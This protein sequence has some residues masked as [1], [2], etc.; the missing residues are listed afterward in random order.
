[1]RVSADGS[2]LGLLVSRAIGVFPNYAGTAHRI[3]DARDGSLLYQYKGP[4]GPAGA[5]LAA[6]LTGDGVDEPFFFGA[7]GRIHVQHGASGE[8]IVHDLPAHFGATPIIADP[9]R[10]GSLEL[11]GVA[12]EN[13]AEGT[14]T[15]V[16]R[17]R[18]LS[19]RLLRLQLNADTPASLSWG[20]YM[21]TS[22]DGH[23][24]P[25][26]ATAAER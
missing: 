15:G 22:L 9:R 17:W 2:R 16:A 20:A 23:Y 6:D 26:T 10:S 1:M 12:W 14:E 3:Y 19:C 4:A 8:L 18:N 11:I 24:R 25:V 21:G 7:R 5:P 13:A